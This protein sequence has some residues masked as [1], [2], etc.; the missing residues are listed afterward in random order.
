[1]D[2]DFSHV[3]GKTLPLLTLLIIRSLHRLPT[4]LRLV[5]LR[6][7]KLRLKALPLT[8]K[9]LPLRRW[10]FAMREDP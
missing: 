5:L 10:Q 4:R 2:H 1:M 8:R 6:A 7:L 3:L 9:A